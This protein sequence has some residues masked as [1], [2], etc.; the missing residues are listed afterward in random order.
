MVSGPVGS[1]PIEKPAFAGLGVSLL[2]V[3]RPYRVDS[4]SRTRGRQC[5]CCGCRVA[6]L[7]LQCADQASVCGM[8]V[9]NVRLELAHVVAKGVESH[10]DEVDLSLGDHGCSFPAVPACASVGGCSQR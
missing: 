5:G 9:G 8:H 6:E 10:R 3:A 2:V 7:L 1:R 4:S